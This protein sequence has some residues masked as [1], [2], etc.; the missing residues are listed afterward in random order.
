ARRLVG[1]ERA[2]RHSEPVLVAPALDVGMRGEDA[3]DHRLDLRRIP[4]R[5]LLCDDL[6]V[7]VERRLLALLPARGQRVPGEAAQE[8]DLTGLDLLVHDV[9]VRLA[10]RARVL[11]HYGQVVRAR[12]G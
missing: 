3:G 5:R 1:R 9:R 11:A 2:G 6:D 8:G 4:V 12:A 10:E 7:R